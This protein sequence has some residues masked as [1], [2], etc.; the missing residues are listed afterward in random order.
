MRGA[1]AS[2]RARRHEAAGRHRAPAPDEHL[3]LGLQRGA[4]NQAVARYLAAAAIARRPGPRRPPPPPQAFSVND[5]GAIG[6]EADGESKRVGTQG[7][8]GAWVAVDEGGGRAVP[9]DDAIIGS[10]APAPGRPD[11]AVIRARKATVTKKAGAAPDADPVA[12]NATAADVK[13]AGAQ[14]GLIYDIGTARFG[15][16]LLTRAGRGA[17]SA[18][19]FPKLPD[20]VRGALT[21][22]PEARLSLTDGSFWSLMSFHLA[23]ERADTT[24]WV[25]AK[26]EVKDRRKGLE[27]DAEKL[28]DDLKKRFGEYLGVVTAVMTH[29]GTYSSRSPGTDPMASIGI[30]Q[31]GMSKAGAQGAGSSLGVFFKDLKRRAEAAAPKPGETA[32]PEQKLY[33][34]AWK[35]CRDAGLDVDASGTVTLNGRATTGKDV[36]DK[37][38]GAGGAMNQGALKTYQLVAAMDWIAKFRETMVR[39]GPS[40][41]GRIGHE[42]SERGSGTSVTLKK[43]AGGTTYTF[44]LDAPDLTANV[45]DMLASGKSTAVAVTLGVNRPHYVEAALWLAMGSGADPKTEAGALLDKLIAAS[46]AAEPEPAAGARRPR[47]PRTKKL[48]AADVAALGPDAVKD[49]AALQRLL[50]PEP[51][52][53]GDEEEQKLVAEFKKRALTLYKA[54]DARR[55]HRERRFATAEAAFE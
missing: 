44:A 11:S 48:T 34:D 42:Y 3:L 45:G 6:V 35:Q 19:D 13:L 51:K 40:G 17:W 10:V 43:A 12:A 18:I 53:M 55:F 52:E 25:P 46:T 37:M 22:V 33:I 24:R 41:A 26:K 4:G 7:A 2:E 9:L 29:E 50:W 21:S 38:A 8:D 15:A 16:A 1:T 36:E 28:P 31:W 14:Q 54:S 5:D 47:R 20:G 30:F 49:F 32:T 39:P 23:D 27:S